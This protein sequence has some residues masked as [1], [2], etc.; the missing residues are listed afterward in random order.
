MTHESKG[1]RGAGFGGQIFSYEP[2]PDAF[3][4]LALTSSRDPRWHAERLAVGAREGVVYVRETAD[5]RFSSIR[6]AVGSGAAFGS[7]VDVIGTVSAPITTLDKLSAGL[8]DGGIGIKLDVQGFEEE[9]LK[10]GVEALRC[11]AFLEIELSLVP[12]YEGQS[13]YMEMLQWLSGRGF[14]LVHVQNVWQVEATGESLQLNGL[15]VRN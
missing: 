6:S 5:S 9:V 11:A 10:G 14:R 2:L 3:E 8:R 13:L 12:V 1:L 7:A 15:F 4:R